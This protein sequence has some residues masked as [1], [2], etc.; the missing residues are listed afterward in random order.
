MAVNFNITKLEFGTQTYELHDNV[1]YGFTSMAGTSALGGTDKYLFGISE[2]SNN[3]SYVPIRTG[4]KQDLLFGQTSTNPNGNV[5]SVW[6]PN[7]LRTWLD[8]IL[9][10]STSELQNIQDLINSLQDED[11]GTGIL[12]M[13]AGL[14]GTYSA[15]L[16][17]TPTTISGTTGTSNKLGYTS[18]NVTSSGSYSHTLKTT[19]SSVVGGSLSN[20]AVTNG[21]ITVSLATNGGA[22]AEIDNTN[23]NSA[24]TTVKTQP[25]ITGNVSKSG[26]VTLTAQTDTNDKELLVISVTDGITVSN[27]NLGVSAV[28]LQSANVPNINVTDATYTASQAASSVTSG[29]VAIT[30]TI[31][32]ATE[33]T[34]TISGP[35]F[36]YDK[37]TS[38]VYDKT[39]AASV[40]I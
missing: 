31:N 14:H 28:A 34:G 29:A 1:Q 38:V 18:T 19:T 32:S 7:V 12:E 4:T 36:S 9:G 5:P 15:S 33:V 21:K 6:T 23:W 40:T 8:D 30:T 13:L 17:Q 35:T 37:L 39:T 22:A 16:T 3:K 20:T 27:G 10:I 25:A 11:L 2:D 24:S 26:T